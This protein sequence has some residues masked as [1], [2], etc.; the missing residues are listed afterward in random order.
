MAA[1]IIAKNPEKYGFEYKPLPRLQ[2]DEVIL[3]KSYDLEAIARVT[4][5]PA[6][7][8]KEYNPELRRWMTPPDVKEYVL[9]VPYGKGEHVRK[10]LKKI[11]HLK[12]GPRWIVH[13]VRRGQ[14]L[15]YIARKYGT[16]VSAIVS[17]NKIRNENQIKVGQKL[18]IPVREYRVTS[19]KKKIVHVVKKGESLYLIARKYRVSV[20]Q[21]IAWNNLYGRRYIY[22]GQRLYIYKSYGS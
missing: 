5:I 4:G 7:T 16:T 3:D 14:T 17:A 1:I 15:W 21:L 11:P 22:P 20:R 6:K 10:N 13:R 9:R 2:W 12:T 18:L 8:L 19:G